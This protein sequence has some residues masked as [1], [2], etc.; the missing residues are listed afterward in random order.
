MRGLWTASR[1]IHDQRWTIAGQPGSALTFTR[2]ETETQRGLTTQLSTEPVDIEKL[3]DD[4][5]N[6]HLADH[7]SD[8]LDNDYQ[9]QVDSYEP[10]NY[11]RPRID[12]IRPTGIGRFDLGYAVANHLA[13]QENAQRRAQAMATNG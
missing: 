9:R 13:N 11:G 2:P 4:L 6:R 3:I 5:L 1:I 7:A 8:Y 12:T 10:T